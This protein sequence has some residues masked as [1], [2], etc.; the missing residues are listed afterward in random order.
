MRGPRRSLITFV[1][2]GAAVL[3]APSAHAGP[4]MPIAAAPEQPDH[5][6]AI[7][8]SASNRD[9][10]PPG[11]NDMSCTP[12]AAHPN[13]VVLVH[14]TDATAYSDWAGFAPILK[15]AGFC[16]FA[17]NYGASPD[18]E[19]NGYGVIE[20]SAAQLKAMTLSI[21]QATGAGAVDVVGYSQ[22]AAVA[23]Y[24]VN[25]LG[26]AYV[27]D[28]WVGIASPTYGGTMYGVAPVVQAVPGATG[29]VA[30][31]F[32]PG[33]AQLMAGS[34]FL[35]RLNAGGDT[36]PGVEYTSIATRVDEVIQPYTNALLRDPGAHNIVVQD[37]CPDTEVAHFTFTYDPTALRLALNALDPANARPPTCVPV[38]LGAGILDVVLA[39]H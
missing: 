7:R 34:D 35:E 37:V 5:A 33:L 22:G 8:Y 28:R 4:V 10:A 25:R 16:V 18:G 9:A 3:L 20:D 15:A 36:V 23:R 39:S 30:G 29:V 13:P 31:E 32:G 12:T 24:F 2:V 38:P 17:I 27:V 26:G 6:D 1:I 14:G 21:L 19:S 11:A